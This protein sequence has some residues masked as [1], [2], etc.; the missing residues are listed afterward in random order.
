M[1]LEAIGET[2]RAGGGIGTVVGVGGWGGLSPGGIAPL[3]VRPSVA[4][5]KGLGAAVLEE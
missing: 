3:A 1:V 5:V 4:V 2:G